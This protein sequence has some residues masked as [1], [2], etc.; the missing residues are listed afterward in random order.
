MCLNEGNDMQPILVILAMLAA[1]ALLLGLLW[2]S[3]KLLRTSMEQENKQRQK[4]EYRLHPKLQQQQ[5]DD[6]KED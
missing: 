4:P 1:A 6:A 2:M 5:K 3:Y